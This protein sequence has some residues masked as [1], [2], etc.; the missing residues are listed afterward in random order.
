N[1]STESVEVNGWAI[2]CRIN[3]ENPLK[4]FMPSPGVI[5]MYLAPCGNGV[6]VDSAAYQDYMISP[7][8]DSMIAKLITF[9]NT[10]KEAVQKMRRALDEFIIEEIGR[11]HV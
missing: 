4:N 1:C 6:R 9:G 11:A 10:R 8:Y 7:H 2:E 3:A 5:D